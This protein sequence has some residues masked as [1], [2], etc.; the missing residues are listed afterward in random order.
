MT[1]EI[2]AIRGIPVGEVALSPN[3]HPDIA[4]IGQLLDCVAMIP[5]LT[6]RPVGVKLAIGGWTFINELCEALLVRGPEFAPDFLTIDGGEGGSGAA[7]LCWRI[8]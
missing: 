5:D 3:R 4:D 7:P 1:P 6:G 2:A 8:T